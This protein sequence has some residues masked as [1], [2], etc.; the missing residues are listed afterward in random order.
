VI[1]SGFVLNSSSNGI[2]AARNSS[3]E[4]DPTESFRPLHRHELGEH[5][6]CNDGTP[7]VFF[8][9][10]SSDPD[11]HRWIIRFE[12]GGNCATENTCATRWADRPQDMT[13]IWDEEIFEDEE[14]GILCAS[15]HLNPDFYD[16]NHAYVHYCSSDSWMGTVYEGDE[17]NDLPYHFI[18]SFILEGT[19]DELLHHHGMTS[20]SQ[21]VVT[22]LSVG[23][24]GVLNYVDRIYDFLGEK[25][26][27]AEVFFVADAG[28]QL[29]NW[30]F[31][32]STIGTQGEAQY[33]TH[34]PALDQ[35]CLAYGYTWECYYPADFQ[36]QFIEHADRLVIMNSMFDKM[37]MG[38]PL[39]DPTTW[40]NATLEWALERG[41][42]VVDTVNAQVHNTFLSNC[43]SHDSMDKIDFTATTIHDTSENDALSEFLHHNG[44]HALWF[45]DSEIYPEANPS[46]PFDQ[47][48][49]NKIHCGDFWISDCTEDIANQPHTSNWTHPTKPPV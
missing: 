8:T 21:I 19:L 3:A 27:E 4:F 23:A 31:G 10:K 30:N 13:T 22:G 28:W 12:G 36:Y 33:A 38:L 6:V 14:G 15:P 11:E 43:R 16:W 24:A 34:R 9:R 20:A 39:G 1:A 35:N 45:M 5:Y 25:A 48:E 26:H 46:C 42:Y 2:N 29:Y 7:A 47:M 44:K 32:I 18:G 49:W 41:H 40:S 37:S 17:G